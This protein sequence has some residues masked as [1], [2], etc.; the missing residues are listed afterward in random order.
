MNKILG[1]LLKNAREKNGL[2]LD[3]VALETKIQKRYL[4]DLEEEEFDDMPGRVYEKGF[5]K[6]YAQALGI[7]EKEV[8]DL[9][10]EIRG[11]KK[12]EIIEEDNSAVEEKHKK[13][14]L[15][16]F[17]SI[18]ALV[19]IGIVVVKT[20][21]IID[22]K[23]KVPEHAIVEE[24]KY[25]YSSEQKQENISADI[26]EIEEIEEVEEE[27]EIPKM[28]KK[29]EIKL[30]GRV[31]LQVFINGKREK[32]GEFDSSETLVFE[33]SETDQIFVKIGNIK[34]AEV[35]FN[36]VAED[37]ST[38]YRNVWKKTF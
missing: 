26:T 7:S 37:E 29:V 21:E 11:E 31:W 16:I 22:K 33:G 10:E 27:L 38:A 15:K 4:A 35:Y 2:S 34:E 20:L 18:I 28:T 17:L 13:S 3:D 32:E 1:D 6:T 19:T 9:Y 14:K 23:S 36:G 5:L 25:E 24:E 30:S 12:A 8:M